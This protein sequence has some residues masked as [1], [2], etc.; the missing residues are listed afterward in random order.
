MR[1]YTPTRN[2]KVLSMQIGRALW[3]HVG[4]R[5]RTVLLKGCYGEDQRVHKSRIGHLRVELVM[6]DVMRKKL[7]ELASGSAAT[8]LVP[9]AMLQ[10]VRVYHLQSAASRIR[11]LHYRQVHV[12]RLELAAASAVQ[13]IP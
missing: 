9:E 2:N 7:L 11:E 1:G 10:N 8:V 13:M 4:G 12:H 5:Q 6:T 3:A